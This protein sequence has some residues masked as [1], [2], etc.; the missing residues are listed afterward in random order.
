[1]NKHIAMVLAIF[2]LIAAPLVLAL[3]L[4]PQEQ[5]ECDLQGGCAVVSR[6]TVDDLVAKAFA[7][8][9]QR[10]RISCANRT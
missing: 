9:Q 8:G 6:A 5:A 7:A 3:E 1:M 10:G 2:A 4:T